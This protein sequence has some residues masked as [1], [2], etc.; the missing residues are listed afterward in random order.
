MEPINTEWIVANR[1]SR[2]AAKLSYFWIQP[3]H[4][5]LEGIFV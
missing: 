1:I 5:Y 3:S 2:W 4:L